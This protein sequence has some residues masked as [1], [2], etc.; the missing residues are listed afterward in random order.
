M[1]FPAIRKRCANTIACSACFLLM[2][3][4][5]NTPFTVEIE[6]DLSEQQQFLDVLILR[7]GSGPVTI[8]LPDGMEGLA[9]HNL[10]TFKSR[11]EALDAWTMK[12]LIGHYVA[13]RKLVSPKPTILLPENQFNLYA[14]CARFP[15]KLSSQVP[16]QERQTGVY[17]CQWGTDT[18]RVVVAG[19]LPRE[20][21]NAPL[22]FFSASSDLKG[23]AGRTYRIRSEHGSKVLQLLN[24]RFGDGDIVMPYTMEDFTHDYVKEKFPQL[25]PRE[26]QEAVERLTAE[27]RKEMLKALPPEERMEGLLP[28]QRLA[29]LPPEQRLAGLSPEEIRKYLD[30]VSA[31]GSAEGRKRKKKQ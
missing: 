14:V 18:V 15:R 30:E 8:Q 12:E 17:D 4:F 31:S 20:E 25:T 26:R 23:Y 16:W 11:Y 1:T 22:Q 24:E 27:Q 21:Q 5:S 6:R 3:F 2:D 9:E 28:E 10:V 13:Y 7:R 29:G 19:R